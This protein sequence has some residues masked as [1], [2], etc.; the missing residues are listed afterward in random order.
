M[1][2]WLTNNELACIYKEAAVAQFQSGGTKNNQENLSQNSQFPG[3]DLN[4]PLPEVE[5]EVSS[6]KNF[7]VK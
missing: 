3:Q 7:P 5:A 2:G 1:S 4:P 6:D